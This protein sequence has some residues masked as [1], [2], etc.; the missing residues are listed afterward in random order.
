MTDKVTDSS[1]VQGWHLKKEIQLGHL[2]T[3]VTVAISAIVYVNKIEQRVAVVESQVNF[4]KET[5]GVLRT[6][7]DRINDKLDRLIE[8]A[9]K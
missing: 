6:Q 2:I 4:Q 3:T 1:G 7:L 5:A 8:R 9:S